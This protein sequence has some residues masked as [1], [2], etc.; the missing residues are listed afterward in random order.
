MGMPSKPYARRKRAPVRRRRAPRKRAAASGRNQGRAAGFPAQ[1]VVSLVYA[2]T[3]PLTSSTTMAKQQVRCSSVFDPDYTGTGHQPMGHDV[4]SAVY[5]HYTVL[6]ATISA[7]FIPYTGASYPFNVGI[8]GPSDD[9]TV[10]SDAGDMIENRRAKNKLMGVSLED[11][12]QLRSSYN[13][14]AFF[15]PTLDNG[16]TSSAVTT[17]PTE[18]AYWTLYTQSLNGVYTAAVFISYKVTYRVR[19]YEPK[20]QAQN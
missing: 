15:G 12:A 16:A 13:R 7:T 18:E 6:S 8:Y 19:Y 5:N 20:D 17:N 11:R 9:S 14:K 4:W 3:T 2:A 10:P 1:K